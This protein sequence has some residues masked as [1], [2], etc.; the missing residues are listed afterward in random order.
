VET[1]IKIPDSVLD[2]NISANAKILYSKLLL[3]SHKKGFSFASNKYLAELLKVST[4]TITKLISEL[5]K[6]DL[7]LTTYDGCHNRQIFLKK[8]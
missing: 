2:R 6:E 7:I 1:Y 5:K 8:N 3:L 4:R